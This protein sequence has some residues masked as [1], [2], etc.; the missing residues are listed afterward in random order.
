MNYIDLNGEMVTP[1]TESM[2]YTQTNQRMDVLERSIHSEINNTAS[3]IDS[4][5]SDEIDTVNGRITTET[6]ALGN[7]IDN[8][9]AHNNDTQGNTELLDIRTGADG[10]IYDCAGK[11]V[12]DQFNQIAQVTIGMNKVNPE[13]LYDGYYAQNAQTSYLIAFVESD[14]YICS[15]FIPITKAYCIT[16]GNYNGSWGTIRSGYTLFDE[17]LAPISKNA[18]Q[19]YTVIDLSESNAKYIRVW[20]SKNLFSAPF[21]VGFS[22]NN[23]YLSYSAY[24]VNVDMPDVNSIGGISIS[25]LNSN[26]EEVNRLS[27]LYPDTASDRVCCWGDSLTYGSG[28]SASSNTYPNKLLA[29]LRNNGNTQFPASYGVLNNGNAGGG[30]ETIAAYQGGIVLNVKPTTIPAEGSVQIELETFLGDNVIMMRRAGNYITSQILFDYKNTGEKMNHC[31]IAGVKGDLLRDANGNYVFT[32]LESGEAVTID[33]PVP[34]ITYGAAEL[35][36]P[37][38]IAVIWAGTNDIRMDIDEIISFI[39]L[40]IDKLGND[41]YIIVGLTAKNYH[42]D[43]ESK[44]RKLG[45]AFGKHF[46]DVRSYILNYGLQDESITATAEDTQAI[47][48][49]MMPPSLMHDATHFND[50]GYDVIANQVYLKGKSLGYWN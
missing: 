44:N 15:G 36:L 16:G 45:L 38:D 47:S 21:Y 26:I 31:Y 39:Q 28:V 8:I 11:A 22:D 24:S 49:G 48:Q 9:I 30:V 35:N 43:I 40:M 18:A 19:T 42:S 2:A 32:R 25:Q 37:S 29:L 27:A 33:R 1:K 41:K 23:E 20:W 6:S 4:R 17:N 10:T 12:R 3:V 34:L 46:L 50:Y 13:D 14:E 7:R 5:I